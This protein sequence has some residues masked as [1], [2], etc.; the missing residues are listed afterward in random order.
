M[1]FG[2]ANGKSQISDMKSEICDLKFR[3]PARIQGHTSMD[4]LLCV[5]PVGKIEAS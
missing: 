1:P 5:I 3:A 2:M 4:T